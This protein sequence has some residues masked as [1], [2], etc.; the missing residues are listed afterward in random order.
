MRMFWR[1]MIEPARVLIENV[2]ENNALKL[3]VQE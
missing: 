3:L 1:I 2:V